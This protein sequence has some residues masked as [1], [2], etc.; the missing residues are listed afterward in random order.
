MIMIKRTGCP[1]FLRQSTSINAYRDERVV[2][3]LWKM[4]NEKCCYCEVKIPEEG[5]GKAVDH[6]GPTSIFKGKRNNWNNLLLACPHCNGAK[7]DQ[8]PVTIMGDTDT[9]RVLYL[10]TPNGGDPAIIDPSD[11]ETDPEEY[12]DFELDMSKEEMGLAKAKKRTDSDVRGKTTISV[13]GLYRDHYRKMHATHIRDMVIYLCL[14]GKAKQDGNEEEVRQCMIQ[15]RIWV[16]ARHKYAAVARA[17]A[18]YYRMD[19]HF[20]LNIPHGWN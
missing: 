10:R 1:A 20:G 2:Q 12:I 7:A 13:I 5:H 8:F 11:G 19:K 4:Q 18:R 9:P 16:S 17:F 6:W 14:I 15:F 3:K